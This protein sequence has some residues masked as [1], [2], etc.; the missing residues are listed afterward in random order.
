MTLKEYID[1]LQTV[2]NLSDDGFDREEMGRVA[3]LKYGLHLAKQISEDQPIFFKDN[4]P[5]EET[6]VLVYDGNKGDN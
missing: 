6:D 3:G 2:I 1:Q 5:S 4:P